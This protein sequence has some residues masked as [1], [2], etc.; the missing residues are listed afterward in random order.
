MTIFRYI[1]IPQW[2]ELRNPRVLTF[3]GRFYIFKNIPGIKP[4]R[5][6]FGVFGFEFG[7]RNPD[8]PV[9]VFLKRIGLWPW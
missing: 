5:W 2:H 7:S 3:W 8:D 1:H 4:G 9:G 6:G